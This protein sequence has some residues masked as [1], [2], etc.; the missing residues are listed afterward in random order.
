MAIQ[1]HLKK[2][3]HF[4]REVSLSFGEHH[5]VW[6]LSDAEFYFKNVIWAKDISAISLEEDP[7]LKIN[8]KFLKIDFKF[9]K[10]DIWN[11]QFGG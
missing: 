10:I 3:T 6:V 5:W 8:L 9:L 2:P 1:W 11:V 4:H 7:V